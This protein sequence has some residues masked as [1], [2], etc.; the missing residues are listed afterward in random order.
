MSP[1]RFALRRI[2][3]ARNGEV[4]AVALSG[5]VDAVNAP[6]L[7]EALREISPGTLVLDL[8]GAEYFGSAAFALLDRLIARGAAVVLGP[9]AVIRRAALLMNVP[10]H[11]TVE[12]ALAACHV[13]AA[14]S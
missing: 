3:A 14:G 4:P 7:E 8:T 9:G 10:L 1:Q 13:R 11:D 6:A 2:D 5:E 12:Q